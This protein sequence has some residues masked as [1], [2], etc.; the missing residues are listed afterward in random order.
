M[1]LMGWGQTLY[2]GSTS[3]ASWTATTGTRWGT[4]EPTYNTTW[5]SGRPAVFNVV[6]STITGATTAFS[7]I[8]AN[9]NVTVTATGT[10]ATGGTVANITVASGKTFNFGSQALSTAAGTGFNK[11]GTGTLIIGG[12][13]TYTGGFTL[14]DGTIQIGGTNSMGTGVL[15]IN[16]GILCPTT[17][18]A[19]T[20]AVSSIVVGGDFQFG[21]A[22]NVSTG[23]GAL[24]FSNN[25]SLGS[26]T[27]T[28]TIG[29]TATYTLGGIISGSSSAG[30]TVN[31][32][33][34][35]ILLLSGVNTYP[36]NTTV[37]S[38][39]LRLN[40]S[41]NL[42]MSG[43][44][45]FNGGKLATTGI[46]S[47][48]TIT[49]SS[50]NISDNSTLALLAAT[51]Q[52]IT[53]TSKGT[54]TTGKTLTITGW[55]GSYVLGTTGAVTA[56]PKVFIGSTA[57][58]TTAELSQIKFNNGTNN[59][60]ASQLSTGEI[61]PTTQLVV[62]AIGN[63]T[64]GI[65]FSVTVTA[66]DLD[67]NARALTNTTGI[68]LSTTTG[69]T[70]GGTTTGSI[71]ASTSGVTISG[72]TLT[73]G[74]AQTITATRSSGDMPIPGTSN[75]FDVVA[76]S[77]NS[78][79][80]IANTS[81]T[82]PINIAYGSYQSTNI[83]NDGNDIEVAEFDIRDGGG[84]ADADALSTDLTAITFS[85][86]NWANIRR[87]AIYDVATEIAEV[88][89]SLGTVTFSSLTG[90]TA[91][92][93]GSKTFSIRASF[94]STVTDNQQFQ[95]TVTS[96]TANAAGSTF[97]AANAGGASS[98]TTGNIN[99]IVV[100]ATKLVFIQQPTNT[101][102]DVAMTPNPTVK[103]VDANNNTD[104]DYSTAVTAT[105]S[106]TLTGSPVSGSW[107]SNVA[108]FSNLVHTASGTGLILTAASSGIT[109]ATSSA[110][111][112]TDPQP[113]INI[114]ESSTDYLSTSTFAFGSVVS[115][116]NSSVKTFTIQNTG[117]ANLT[118]TGTPKVA[119]SGTNASEFTIDQTSTISPVT[120][121]GSTTFT[122][123]FSPTSQG[124]KTAQISIDNND[125]TGSENPYIINLTGTGTV[126]SASDITNASGYSFTSN[127]AYAS[128]QTTST[129]TTGNSVGV[130]GLTIRDG[131]GTTDGDNLGT[132]LTAISF[133]TG[134]FTAI[135]TAALFDGTSNVSEV[136]VNG[137]ITIAF[138]GL[139]LSAA[140]GGT[141]DFELRVTFTGTVTDN[142]QIT[143]TV[144][145]ATASA[146]GSGF[147]TGNAGGAASTATGDF[148]RIEVTAT[149]IVF[150]TSPSIT[151]CPN[152]NLTTPPVVTARD[153]ND[154]TDLDFTGQ[155]TLTN[156][157]S[158]GMSNYQMS[159]GSGVANFANLQ[160]TETGNVTLSTT[161]SSGLTNDGP[162]TS[163]AISVS[164]VSGT[165]ATNGN[166][167]S[168]V[169]WTN[170]SC[171]DEIMIVAKAGS[172]VTATP[173]GDGSAYTGNLAFGSGT[174]FD[175]GFVVYKASTSSQTVTSL[176]NGTTYHFT[177]F[178]RKGS[179]WSSGVITTA[180]PEAVTLATDYF[181]SKASG[182]WNVA[183][184]WESS[185]D[186]N[187]WSNSTLTPTTSANTVTILNGHEVTVSAN[188]SV[189]QVVINA[190]IPQQSNFTL[191]I[192][193]V[194]QTIHSYC[195]PRDCSL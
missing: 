177:F 121:L 145:A 118:L 153:A 130:N 45:T 159:A 64:A 154:N 148:N 119:I 28:I 101:Q 132:T 27:R 131:A 38:G 42:S 181:R 23:T 3:A 100:A 146:T 61:V 113:E 174:G 115:G 160:F 34:T 65:G 53:F 190:A 186:G 161:N 68:A 82:Y 127:V 90:L 71:T 48:R 162:T 184:T 156:S 110:F 77:S 104:L 92:D 54:F 188:V 25:V 142:Q 59:Y 111:D 24:T 15:T 30:L 83:I 178:T 60:A 109:D 103:A 12:G 171:Y 22:V 84:S 33:S 117:A 120:A 66:K 9:E 35:G 116:N 37:T 93:N 11:L 95:L 2:W 91:T 140:D 81:F 17:S 86:S 192:T 133:S 73:A 189:D 136:A 67:G 32:T 94:N 157:G 69:G 75:A 108:T 138:S 13:A 176:T 57:S 85:L 10:L 175:G 47:T 151:A 194:L 185:A 179:S 158:I 165:G 139:T 122:I 88:A 172:A 147:A 125:A 16:G 169:S 143:Y 137:A 114:Q 36:G 96:V 19:R 26:A 39:E 1:G 173:S 126:S 183:G 167:Q 20:P 51:N 74:T 31:S 149:K 180:T 52:T 128:Y 123:T 7:S 46:A 72:V 50:I 155:V 49:F 182:N 44:C 166:A 164:N 87:L 58:L 124:A 41:G 5:V 4:V 98:S 55:T 18:T 129:L 168:V 105:S 8:T 76:G 40:P 107:A 78:S 195:Y 106:G 79:D 193:E 187:S 89:V 70:I 170:P 141:K 62:S 99:R 63:Q 80:I 97:A 144:S 191:R 21:D 29:G 14:S 135:R 112:I 56:A 152:T 43:A 102:K 163:I 6:N 150:T 134:G